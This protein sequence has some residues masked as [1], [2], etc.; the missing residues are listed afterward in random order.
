[1]K[2][3]QVYLNGQIVPADQANI[4]IFD[5]GLLY[6]DGVFESLRT[7]NQKVFQLEDHL[8]RVLRSAKYIRINGLPSIGKLKSA[9]LKT[10]AANNFKET[11]IKIVISRGIA[12]EH[13]LAT[14]KVKG[15][16]NIFII[17]AEQKPYPQT[18][19][20]NGW[21]AIISSITRANTPSSRIKSLCYLD[22]ILARI[23]A[24]KNAANE[25]FLLDDKGNV[26][27]GT[28][29][30]IFVVKHGGIFTSPE[31]S[32]IVLGLTRKL[33]IKLAKQSAFNVTEKNLTPKE[34]YTADECFISF[35]GAG[36]VPIT[37]IWKKRVGNGKPGHITSALIRLYDDETKKL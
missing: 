35:S 27:E 4:S 8:K 18:V 3:N 7:Y 28:I 29:S 23:E 31:N 19:F 12:L 6:G 1:M 10:L 30:N 37:R 2:K 16:P 24:K 11:Y 17:A 21:K 14:N 15:K 5:R 13:G 26:I 32:P 34:I 25:A 9:V 33:V 22:N 36:V 20:T